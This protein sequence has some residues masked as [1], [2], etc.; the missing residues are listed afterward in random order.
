MK[1]KDKFTLLQK[2]PKNQK[3]K[4]KPKTNQLEFMHL[5]LVAQSSH[6]LLEDPSC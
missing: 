2:N 5:F 4:T 3:P 1:L 6:E